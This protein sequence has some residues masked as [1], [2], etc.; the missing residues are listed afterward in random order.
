MAECLGRIFAV[1]PEDLIETICQVMGSQDTIMKATL[2]RSAKYSG[3]KAH[4][5]LM[6]EMLSQSLI[7]QASESDHEVKKYALEG[8]TTIVHCNWTVVKRDIESL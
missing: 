1:Y 6:F 2:A 4:N 5:V 7:D 8:L 3:Q